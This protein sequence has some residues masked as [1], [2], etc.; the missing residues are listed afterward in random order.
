MKKLII[1]AAA[2]MVGYAA[3]ATTYQW[4]ALDSTLQSAYA[5][6]DND[7]KYIDAGT[8]AYLALVSG[9]GYEDLVADYADG[10]VNYTKFVQ[11]AN[12]TVNA[13]GG[14]GQTSAFSFSPDITASEKA[15]FVIFEGDKMFISGEA[16]TGYLA[17][18]NQPFSF[19]DQTDAS[20]WDV[21]GWNDANEG[22]AGAG[23]YQTVPEPTSGLLLLL[24]VAGLALRRRRA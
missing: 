2:L 12:G 1:A 7:W 21:N 5:S 6:E 15:Y 14:I 13:A 11:G 10:K 24:G 3:N 4:G 8:T 23:W 9:Y 16:D 18:G 20:Y 19:E 17:F 22:Y